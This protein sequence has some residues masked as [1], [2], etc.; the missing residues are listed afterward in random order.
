MKKDILQK[1]LEGIF[2]FVFKN[3][4]KRISSI[5]ESPE[6]KKNLQN[7]EKAIDE[8]NELKEDPEIKKKLDNYGIKLPNIDLDEKN[9]SKDDTKK[10]F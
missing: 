7:L 3:D 2:K 8:A 5:L 6:H 9:G 1:S 4:K 10:R